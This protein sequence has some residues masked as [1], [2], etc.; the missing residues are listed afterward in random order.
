MLFTYLHNAH[1]EYSYVALT[2][3]YIWLLEYLQREGK[4]LPFFK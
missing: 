2:F 3:K 4:L 1:N